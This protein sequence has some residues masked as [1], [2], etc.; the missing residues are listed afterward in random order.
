MSKVKLLVTHLNLLFT[1]SAC[2]KIS[3]NVL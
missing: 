1:L 3:L 2:A